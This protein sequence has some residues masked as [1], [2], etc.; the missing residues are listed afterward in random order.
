[1]MVVMVLI[2]TNIF[3]W[4]FDA[5][6]F[7]VY[8]ILGQTMFTIFQDATTSAMSS[9]IVA[10][11]LIKKVHIQKIVFPTANCLFAFVNFIIS[12]IAVFLVML[13]CN[14]IP[15]WKLI[16]LPVLLLFMLLFCLGISYLISA[17]A[18]YFHDVM[19]L[20]GVITTVLFYFTP[21]FWPYGALANNG[22]EWVYNLIQFNP[23]FH[24]VSCFRQM[25]TG[26]ALSQVDIGILPELAICA[27]FGIVTFVIGLLVFRKLEKKFI[28]YI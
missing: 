25:A 5:Y 1:M 9:I 13:V 17:L 7:P 22:I 12:L 3:R 27:G 6:S 24:F 20:W 28:L 21:I 26:V 10:A 16:L 8:L 14:M 2:F 18:V 15:S 19:H 11:P 4:T 23:L